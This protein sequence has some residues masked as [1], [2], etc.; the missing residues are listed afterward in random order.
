MSML[1]TLALL[2]LPARGD[3]APPPPAAEAPAESGA[4]TFAHLLNS[5]EQV[6]TWSAYADFAL[7][8][9]ANGPATFDSSHFN[10]ILGARL[11]DKL[12][13]EL[14]LEFEHAGQIVKMEYGFLDWRA[15]SGF[16]LR[17]GRF[18]VPIG[19]YNDRLHPSFRWPQLERPELSEEVLPVVWSDV[20]IQALGDV[21]LGSSVTASWALYVIN[22]LGGSWDTTLD[23][24]L[25]DLRDNVID[26]N[27]DKGFGGR[28]GATVL[29]G[30]SRVRFDLS[31][32]TGALD[33]SSAIR[34]N[35]GD[36]SLDAELGPAVVRSE[37]ALS[38]LKGDPW[39]LGTY[40]ATGV[41]IQRVEPTLRWDV[42]QDLP[43][44]A[45]MHRGVASLK[46]DIT[47][48]WNLRGEVG[49][50]LTDPLAEGPS[51]GVM[52]AFFF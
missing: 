30:A 50:S 28:V 47:P 3:E 20:G 32:Y 1:L 6:I 12:W 39:K 52:S 27:S 9:P 23:P 18:L 45:T 31:G 5:L 14:E 29:A 25:R 21:S 13:A 8:I 15:G 38:T 44:S 42:V 49:M 35:L 22:G 24:Y 4:D 17:M 40:L 2:A 43:T 10:P 16:T 48:Q 34:L 7:L 37:V 26:N 46:V 36:A 33:D 41:R 11:S 51:G 19:A